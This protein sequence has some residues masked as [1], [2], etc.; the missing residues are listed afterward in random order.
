MVAFSEMVDSR[1]FFALIFVGIFETTLT[2]VCVNI[3]PYAY[4]LKVE[5]SW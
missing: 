2:S 3:G 4:S 5:Y 1:G